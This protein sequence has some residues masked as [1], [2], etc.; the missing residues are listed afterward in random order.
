MTLTQQQV[1]PIVTDEPFSLAVVDSDGMILSTNGTWRHIA[2]SGGSWPGRSGP[3]IN[4][5]EICAAATGEDQSSAQ[6]AIDSIRN[7]T[8]GTAEHACL[9]YSCEVPDLGKRFFE[10][11]MHGL[12]DSPGRPVVITHHDVTV[13]RRAGIAAY[14]RQQLLGSLVEGIDDFAIY[15][16]SPTGVILSWN[17]GAKT[18]TGWSDE[19]VIGKDY[20]MLFLPDDQRSGLPIAHLDEA[21]S[22]GICKAEGW[23]TRKTGGHY[24]AFASLYPLRSPAGVL[25]GFAKVCGDATALHQAESKLAIAFAELQQRNTELEQFVYTV[26]HDLKTPLVTIAGFTSHAKDDVS[27]QRL[28]R[29]PLFLERVL[30]AAARMHL[31][32]D[33]LLKLSSLGRISSPFEKIDLANLVDRISQE[34]GDQFKKHAATLVISESLPA[35]TADPTRIREVFENLIGNALKHG[36]PRPGMQIEIRGSR[37]HAKVGSNASPTAGVELQVID[38][39]NGV[40]P[41]SADR[42]FGLFQRLSNKTEGTGV[43]LAIVRR[44]MEVHGGT[45]SVA[46]TPGGGATFKLFIP[47]LP[48]ASQPAPRTTT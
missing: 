27:Q 21:L 38:H 10:T 39:G 31:T 19:E 24:L 3:G 16:L 1:Q 5:I 32:L 13:S 48:A 8:N 20:S 45:A 17:T 12:G 44:V 15:M 23:R 22:H 30:A 40:P 25:I 11:R 2:E 4:Y 26:S 42:V 6:A 41:E 7:I 9:S 36:C 14:Q 28:D 29:I 43:G 46:P 37:T 33:D 18:L 35:F 47:D 34:M